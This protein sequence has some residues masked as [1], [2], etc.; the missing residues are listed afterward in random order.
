MAG[1]SKWANI[2][3]RKARQDAKRGKVFTKIIREITVAAKGGPDPADNP[4]LRLALDK[5]AAVGAD[6]PAGHLHLLLLISL[7][8]RSVSLSM[9][10]SPTR[11]GPL[12][13][14]LMTLPL[15]RPSRILTLT[16]VTPPVTPVL[17]TISI[18]SAGYPS[19]LI[20]HTPKP[21]T[22]LAEMTLS[23][24][25]N[26]RKEKELILHAASPRL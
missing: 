12:T 10:M 15:S 14:L 11:T 25:V 23:L 7:A 6:V 19:S 9:T 21:K 2:K 3:H 24:S 13:F 20:P 18:T 26:V 8:S 16:W 17:P 4:R 1:H 22:P 5:A